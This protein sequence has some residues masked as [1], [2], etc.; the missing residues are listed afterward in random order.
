VSRPEARSAGWI[1]ILSWLPAYDRR[2]L[3]GDVTAGIAV[4]L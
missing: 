4:T 1:P 2:W 3:R